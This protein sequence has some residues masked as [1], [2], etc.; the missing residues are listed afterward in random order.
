MNPNLHTPLWKARG[1]GF[2]TNIEARL[3]LKLGLYL[4]WDVTSCE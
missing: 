3:K 2:E 4:G 1:A